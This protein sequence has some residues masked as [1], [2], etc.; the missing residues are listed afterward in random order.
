MEQTINLIFG[1]SWV[2]IAIAVGLLIFFYKLTRSKWLIAVVAVFFLVTR[3]T[4]VSVE[5][6][7]IEGPIAEIKAPKN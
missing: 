4:Y 6:R 3:F 1:G 7:P 2:G 5:T